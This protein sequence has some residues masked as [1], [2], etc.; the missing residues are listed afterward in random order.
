MNWRTL[1]SLVV[2]W[3]FL[4]AVVTG[5]VLY[6]VPQGRVAYWVDWSLLSLTKTAWGNIHIIF[7]AVFIVMGAFHVYFNWKPM[8][9]YMVERAKGHVHLRKEL[10]V[11]TGLSFL[12]L[13]GAIAN[14][15]PVSWLFD[16]NAVTKQAWI[17]SPEL[18]PP[19]GHA[20]ETS[21][22]G[23]SRRMGMDL[24]K[25]T[26]ELRAAG[27]KFDSP[28]DSLKTIAVANGTNPLNVYLVIKKFEQAPVADAEK[29]VFSPELVEEKFS[30]TG[31]GR[32]T[33]EQ[34]CKEIKFPMAKVEKRFAR[35]KIE[36]KADEKMKAIAERYGVGAIDILKV[37]LVPKY[38]L[39][40]S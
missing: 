23:F 8:K 28:R 5:I 30:G 16:L 18:E 25:V 29:I 36:W 40:K 13:V 2:T 6:I 32:K 21:L 4:V 19:Y 35:A 3:S 1:T 33:V 9:K 27:Y 15:P 24:E 34:I 20:E 14:V 11:A 38:E 10:V 22:A 26:K 37:I 17:T 7:G 39:K 31:V 12:I